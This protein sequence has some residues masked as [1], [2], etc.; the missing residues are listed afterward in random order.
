MDHLSGTESRGGR[1][2]RVAVVV[3]LVLRG[4]A[5]AAAQPAVPAP[6]ADEPREG[7]FTGIAALHD[8]DGLPNVGNTF[9]DD[10]YS[11]GMAL[12]VSG[13]AI[14]DWR[15]TAPLEGLDWLTQVSG[16]HRA[17]A[18]QAHALIVVGAAYTPNDLVTT[19]PQRGDRPFA[20]LVGVTVRRLSVARELDRSWTSELMVG[21][22]GLDA[23]RAIQATLH[24]TRRWMTGNP[25][26]PDPLGWPNQISNG[27]E[28]TALYRV[29]YDRRLA[30][31]RAGPEPKRWQLTGGVEGSV[32]YQTNVA[33][34][35][36]V[37]AGTFTTEFWEFATGILSPGLGSQP[38][39]YARPRWE[40]FV[41]GAA[42][43]R[44]VAYNALLQGQFRSSVHTVRPRHVIGE[45][46]GGLGFGGPL[47]AYQVQLIVG[48]AQGRTAE[49]VG[50]GATPST[51]GTVSIVVSRP[52][53]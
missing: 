2:V 17:A 46:E 24:R 43:P 48:L 47:A 21:A 6:P 19:A 18:L 13:R 50:A 16:R 32:G 42:R 11:A 27:G 29:T 40:A 53:R 25:V 15:L 9:R 52:G 38:R 26:P 28:P 36:A 34:T 41:F 37:R 44:L 30:G 51:W 39:G 45:W 12:R 22:L 5:Y 20:S 4:A 8:N 3:A 10:N 33:G 7:L 1:W 49:W 35:V 14:R 23:A 31:G